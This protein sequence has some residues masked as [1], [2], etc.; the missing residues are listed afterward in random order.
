MFT[1]LIWKLWWPN[2]VRNTYKPMLHILPVIHGPKSDLEKVQAVT[3]MAPSPS[4]LAVNVWPGCSQVFYEVSASWLCMTALSGFDK[5]IEVYWYDSNRPAVIPAALTSSFSCLYLWR[6]TRNLTSSCVDLLRDANVLIKKTEK[7]LSYADHRII[8]LHVYLNIYK[9]CPKKQ[10]VMRH[11]ALFRSRYKKHDKIHITSTS[12]Y[13][14]K[15]YLTGNWL[16]MWQIQILNKN[17]AQL[18]VT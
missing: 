9:C 10:R 2:T 5:W 4:L 1:W 12:V 14:K 15:N 7:I 18:F 6:D 13:L 17:R 8:T 16:H 3:T 11:A